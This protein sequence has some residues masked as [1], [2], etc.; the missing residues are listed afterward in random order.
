M[1]KIVSITIVDDKGR[2]ETWTGVGRVETAN[3][4]EPIKGIPPSKW[5]KVT[6]VYAHL[7]IP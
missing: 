7:L 6:Y 4:R 1:P 2:T 5:K 3:T